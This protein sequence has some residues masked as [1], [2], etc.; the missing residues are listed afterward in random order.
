LVTWVARWAAERPA[1]PAVASGGRALSYGELLDAARAGASVLARAGVEP[2]DRVLLAAPS[3][4]EFVVAYLATHLAGA[5]AVPV[6]P[7]L[8]A[9]QLEAVVALVRPTVFCAAQGSRAG[10]ASCHTLALAELAGSVAADGA[11]AHRA[12][13]LDDAADVLLTSGT[14]GVPK[15]T[16]L[17]HRN[18]AAAARNINAFVGTDASDVEVLALPLNH[19]FGLGRLRCQLVAGGT[20]VLVPGFMFPNRLFEALETW[21]ASGFSFVPAAWALLRRLTGE[22]LARFADRLRY[23]EIGSAPMPLEDKRLLVRLF[24]RTRLCMHYGLTEA[25]RSAFIEFHASADRLDS[26]GR[27]SPNVELAVADGAGRLLGAGEVG[28]LVVRGEHV[29]PASWTPHGPVVREGEWLDTG[30]V[31]RIDAGGYVHLLGRAGDVINVGGQKVAPVEVEEVL[32]RHPAVREAA[33]VGVPD[34]HG[35]VGLRVK[36][37]LVRAQATPPSAEELEGFVRTRLEPYKIP[38][39]YEWIDEIPKNELGKPR[40]HLLRSPGAP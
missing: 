2:G 36:A 40:R 23:I 8:A 25:S 27:A 5:T 14:T 37:F 4:V 11:A 38:V 35:L 30:D 18:V 16:L 31:G 22:G 9:E 19:S 28:A 1:H 10:A 20:L 39:A 6:T 13:A 29:S 12:P 7:K 34:P 24:P 15:G 3:A 33:C 26:V 21:Q 17:T 32:M